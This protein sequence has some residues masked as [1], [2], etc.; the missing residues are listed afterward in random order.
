MEAGASSPNTAGTGE[1]QVGLLGDDNLMHP[2]NV[3]LASLSSSRAGTKQL[4]FD[5]EMIALF[6]QV[7]DKACACIAT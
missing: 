6:N 1:Q 5:D 7:K 2:Q 4:I 3:R